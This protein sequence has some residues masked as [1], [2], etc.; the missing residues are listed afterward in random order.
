[1]TEKLKVI[2][3]I[4]DDWKDNTI[5]ETSAMVAISCELK[6]GRGQFVIDE[7]KKLHKSE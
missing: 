6:D 5:D 7:L 3:Q 2:Q 1:M 4:V